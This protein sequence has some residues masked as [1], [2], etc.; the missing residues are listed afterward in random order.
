M[1]ALSAAVQGRA[2]FC[3]LERQACVLTEVTP[4]AYILQLGRVAPGYHSWS[5]ILRTMGF[6]LDVIP[7]WFGGLLGDVWSSRRDRKPQQI[8][9]IDCGL[10]VISGSQEGF[11]AGWDHDRASSTQGDSTSVEGLQSRSRCARS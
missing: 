3:T 4:I 10:R 1:V 9:Q 2:R 8:G 11:G 7:G 6:I 5:A